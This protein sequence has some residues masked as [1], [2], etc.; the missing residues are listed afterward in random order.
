MQI[1]D[2]VGR[3]VYVMGPS[4]SGKDSVINYARDHLAKTRNRRIVIAQSYI[5]RPPEVS[6]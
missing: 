1:S 6:G 4:G 3:L 5:T 2:A